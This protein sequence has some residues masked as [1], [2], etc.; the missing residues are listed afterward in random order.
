MSSKHYICN[1]H[2]NEKSV[3][4][5]APH[6]EHERKVAVFDLLDENHFQPEGGSDGP[7]ELHLSIEENRLIFDI[8]LEIRGVG[9][10]LSEQTSSCFTNLLFPY[11]SHLREFFSV[12]KFQNVPVK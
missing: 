1:I 12:P 5:R 4:R 9:N 10:E 6:V 2:L 11:L 3:V 7:F 8:F